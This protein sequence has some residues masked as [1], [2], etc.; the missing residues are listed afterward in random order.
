MMPK[1][2]PRLSREEALGMLRR[3]GVA[4]G[5]ALLGVRGYYRRTMGDATSND[6]GIYD[7][8][9]FLVTPDSFVA[10]NANADPTVK[11]RPGLAQLKPG[12]YRYKV[13]TH[14]LNRPKA[15]R[16]TALVQASPV[17]V[18]RDGQ[19]PDT[20]WFGINIHRGGSTTSSLGCQTIP[21]S[22]WDEFIAAVQKALRRYGI[23]SLPYALVE[24]G[25]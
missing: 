16:Y 17:T 9:I 21:R 2:R 23:T 14:G 22:Q 1:S 8:A 6:R 25:A 19:G 7:D 18:I 24:E 12:V 11:F 13:G 4:D 3:A 5:V 10:F 20:G 15:Q